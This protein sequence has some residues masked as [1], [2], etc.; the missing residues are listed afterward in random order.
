[1][2]DIRICSAERERA[3]PFGNSTRSLV[4]YSRTHCR[5]YA[6]Y[7]RDISVEPERW[8]VSSTRP[9][10]CMIAGTHAGALLSIV[11][12]LHA[13]P[14]RFEMDVAGS[15]G[16]P[17]ISISFTRLLRGLQRTRL[18]LA[19]GRSTIHDRNEAVQRNSPRRLGSRQ[20]RRATSVLG[21]SISH[22]VRAANRK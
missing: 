9:G 11:I 12:S 5:S 1:M 21:R 18:P 7:G 20:E 10:E 16:A 22:P 6:G 2:I 3:R 15:H 17:S 4:K 13:R 14:T 8:L 19:Q